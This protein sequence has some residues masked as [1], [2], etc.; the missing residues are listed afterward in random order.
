VSQVSQRTVPTFKVRILLLQK[1]FGAEIKISVL[2]SGAIE[3]PLGENATQGT[4]ATVRQWPFR[5]LQTIFKTRSGDVGYTMDIEIPTPNLVRYGFGSGYIK[6]SPDSLVF[7]SQFAD[8]EDRTAKLVEFESVDDV[9]FMAVVLMKVAKY[10][11]NSTDVSPDE[12]LAAAGIK[13]G[14]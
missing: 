14:K 6:V 7:G 12:V 4:L 9:I 1:T 5:P 13:V 2:F 11:V 3:L 8:D 10:L